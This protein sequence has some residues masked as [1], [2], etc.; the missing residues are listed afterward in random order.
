[1]NIHLKKVGLWS[2]TISDRLEKIIQWACI[3]IAAVMVLDILI[4]I[5][6]RY[7]FNNS[8]TWAE[9]VGRYTM[10]FSAFL[11]LGLA[12]KKGQHVGITFV[13]ERL[14]PNLAIPVDIFGRI[15]IGI[16]LIVM[17]VKGI[18]ICRLVSLQTSPGLG[19]NMAWIFL[20]IPISSIIQLIFLVLMSLEDLYLGFSGRYLSIRNLKINYYKE[21]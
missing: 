2:K 7:V 18:D 19:I 11:G 3:T 8:F 21:T 16:F 10:I 20:I 6:A 14:K 17:T 12:L 4:G 5:V 1:M 13:I 15:T 9:E